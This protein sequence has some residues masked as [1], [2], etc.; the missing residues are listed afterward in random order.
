MDKNYKIN[1]FLSNLQEASSIEKKTKMNNEMKLKF[2][3][4]LPKCIIK[5]E[6]H[7]Q[8]A[9]LESFLLQNIKKN[10]P[11]CF[12][13]FSPLKEI[14]N[15][16]CEESLY[17]VECIISNLKKNHTFTSYMEIINDWCLQYSLENCSNELY[18]WLKFKINEKYFEKQYQYHE[19]IQVESISFGT[20]VKMQCFIQHFNIKKRNNIEMSCS[21]WHDQRYLQLFLY[22]PHNS[23]CYST[24]SDLYRFIIEYNDIMRIIIDNCRKE[25][26]ISIYLYLHYPP[27]ISFSIQQD[28]NNKVKSTVCVIKDKIKNTKFWER[29][30]TIGCECQQSKHLII[31]KEI[32][33]KCPVL[34]LTI[35][36]KFRAR[37]IIN[38]LYQRYSSENIYF[39]SIQ[40]EKY[41]FKTVKEPFNTFRCQYAWRALNAKSFEVLDQIINN[42][43]QWNDFYLQL[44][45]Y[46]DTNSIAL[47]KALFEFYNY[48][49][50]GFIF[51]FLNAI[52]VLFTYYCNIEDDDKIDGLCL[53]RRVF[54]TPLR[55]LYL[56]PQQHFE[57]RVLRRYNPDFALRISI[58]DDNLNML[59]HGLSK[60]NADSFLQNTIGKYLSLGIYIGNRHYTFL[61]ASPS[62]LR[63]HGVWMYAIDDNGN[64]SESII[65]WLGD[66]SE[67]H[68][69]AKLMA[70]IGQCFSNSEE[71]FHLVIKESDIKYI[72][73]F[74]CKRK[75]KNMPPYIFTDGVGMISSDIV[76]KVNKSLNKR[77]TDIGKEQYRACA[78]Q[79]RLAGCK[80]MLV[81]NPEL[82][83]SI[84]IRNSMKKFECTNS[85]TLEIIKKSAPRSVFLNRPL[86]TILEQLGIQK[87]VFFRL[88][89][90]MI[91]E[92][93]DAFINNSETCKLLSNNIS[94][95]IPF[96][97]LWESGIDLKQEPFFNSLLV[98]VY[99]TKM[100]FL[101]SK[102]RIA[103]PPEFGRNMF[104]VV[105]ETRTLNYG[106]VF[107]QYSEKISD[108]ESPLHVL[109]GTVLVTKCPCIHPGDVRKF[110]AV[111]VPKLHH[112]KDCIVFPSK[113]HR[114]HPDEM[115]GS[116]LDG[117]EYV[118]IWMPELIFPQENFKPM[119]FPIK[120][121]DESKAVIKVQDMVNFLLEYIKKDNI[122]I[123][124]NA[125]IAWADKEGIFS[126]NCLNIAKKYPYSLDFAKTG[127]PTFLEKKE[128]P[129]KY[130][131]FM[132]KG[133]YNISYRSDRILGYLFRYSRNLQCAI[134]HSVNQDPVRKLD[135]LLE[136]PGWKNY[137]NSA[138][139]DRKLYENKLL[140][141]LQRFNINSESE[142][143]SGHIQQISKY[144][145]MKGD[146]KNLILLIEK[147]LQNLQQKFQK[148]FFEDLEREGSINEEKV[149]QKA[150]AWYMVTYSQSNIFFWSFPWC[151]ASLLAEI[152]NQRTNNYN[153]LRVQNLEC[154]PEKIINIAINNN[155]SIADVNA[156]NLCDN[157]K[158][159]FNILWNLFSSYSFSN[160]SN[161]EK[162]NHKDCFLKIYLAYKNDKCSTSNT[163]CN[164]SPEFWILNFLK[165]CATSC[166]FEEELQMCNNNN[167]IRG[168]NSSL[169]YFALTIY[170]VL[171]V[172]RNPSYLEIS[173]DPDVIN[174]N[175]F[176]S[177]PIMIS[178][179]N[180]TLQNLLKEKW[181]KIKNILI[182]NSGVKDVY[183]RSV[184]LREG[185]MSLLVNSVG[186]MWNCWKLEELLLRPDLHSILTELNAVKT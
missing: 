47:E 3:S 37:Y 160:L 140:I 131:D 100:E 141:L 69:V 169:N 8:L 67:I 44:K 78:F 132:E 183:A 55:I 97:K 114:P 19:D 39:S 68:N 34:K 152:K 66:F 11:N 185:K 157:R 61:G 51:S 161:S 127:N 16:K 1:L 26:Y 176:E 184:T 15:T 99:K 87:E 164:C 63:D 103:V 73:D 24:N 94:L 58:R 170:T 112:I 32:L 22:H 6:E 159:A 148:K 60:H 116:D 138:N 174:F 10:H 124:G 43:S 104:G 168:K 20:F 98:N 117:D 143:F 154:S 53:I 74:T 76:N 149:Y 28:L 107:I 38:R 123:L 166:V 130:P 81:E 126:N 13:R 83:H 106:E 162:V 82:Q 111:D 21:F 186:K 27:R 45:L 125:H 172:T 64:T 165:F 134:K 109:K 115:G 36:D 17:E 29:T 150:S 108:Y 142:I 57:N 179:E 151:V 31:K 175:D 171:T 59:T 30:T 113:G 56:P 40:I 35:P 173:N 167:C 128:K 5:E 90:N 4:F 163:E 93:T 86:I 137:E 101:K 50:K 145:Q 42:Y 25:S 18:Y 136:Y 96:G 120:S 177:E 122:G 85:Y 72:A 181:E 92:Y 2:S 23:N 147:L 139:E 119:D 52:K 156:E 95:D 89:N 105:D 158:I 70:R 49:E 129:D 118:V 9:N 7:K 41:Q 77:C 144:D 12:I 14:S 182:E 178:V 71:P 91:L 62:Q 133:H 121:K 84:I 153:S 65:N 80:G 155:S 88:Q 180:E 48:L 33:G 110:K 102:T 135:E 54:I 75:R 46:E 79:I 146:N